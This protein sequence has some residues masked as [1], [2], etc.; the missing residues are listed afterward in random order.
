MINKKRNLL[1]VTLLASLFLALLCLPGVARAMSSPGY[2]LDWLVPLTGGGGPA[3]S[4][5]YTAQM[6]IGQSVIRPASSAHY[7]I[8]LGYWYG[9][10]HDWLL[11]LPLVLRGL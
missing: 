3:S 1:L 7:E 11:Y 5:Q 10:L 2:V 8:G 6:T 9:L 4:T